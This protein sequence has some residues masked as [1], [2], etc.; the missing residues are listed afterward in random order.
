MAKPKPI[1]L[2]VTTGQEL[3]EQLIAADVIASTVHRVV[4][5]ANWEQPMRLYVEH[6]GGENVAEIVAGLMVK[7]RAEKKPAKPIVDKL[8]TACRKALKMIARLTPVQ[9]GGNTLLD[10]AILDSIDM[11]DKVRAELRMAIKEATDAH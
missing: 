8:E 6:Y 7:H 5:D 10:Q 9:V 4:I 2:D 3:I 1:E 11:A